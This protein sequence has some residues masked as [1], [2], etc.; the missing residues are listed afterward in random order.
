MFDLHTD[1]YHPPR[2]EVTWHN[3]AASTN[4]YVCIHAYTKSFK[5]QTRF[6]SDTRKQTYEHTR[7]CFDHDVKDQKILSVHLQQFQNPRH[8]K[9]DVLAERHAP[10]ALCGG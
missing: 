3:E 7:I 6:H 2:T 4:V 8:Q 10:H 5:F 9:T 1:P